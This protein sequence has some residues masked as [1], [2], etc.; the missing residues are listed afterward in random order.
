ME[1]HMESLPRAIRRL[2][3]FD[4][5]Q[6]QFAEEVGVSRISIAKWESGVVS[7]GLENLRRLVELGLPQEYLAGNDADNS[8][9]D[10]VAHPDTEG[11]A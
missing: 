4:M 7:P 1:G 9:A 11:A 5:T 3:G 6:L 2:R 8:T 10:D